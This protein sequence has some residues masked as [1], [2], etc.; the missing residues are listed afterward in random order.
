MVYIG[1]NLRAAVDLSPIGN[2]DLR[3]AAQLRYAILRLCNDFISNN[4]ASLTQLEVSNQ[5]ANACALVADEIKADKINPL[6]AQDKF[7]NGDVS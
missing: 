6:M 5:A 2:A 1:K 3:S 7:D 4:P